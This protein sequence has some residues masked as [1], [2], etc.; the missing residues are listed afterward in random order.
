MTKPR[1]EAIEQI[2]NDYHG[3]STQELDNNGYK[4]SQIPKSQISK[5]ENDMLTMYS[6][7]D[8]V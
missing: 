6:T 1:A 8:G 4:L 5:L 3:C 2:M 7:E